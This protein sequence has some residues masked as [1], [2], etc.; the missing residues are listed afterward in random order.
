MAFVAV[1]CASILFVPFFILFIAAIACIGMLVVNFFV[2]LI[3]HLS[4]PE[5]DDDWDFL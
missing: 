4:E 1:I 2:D 5:C 3:H